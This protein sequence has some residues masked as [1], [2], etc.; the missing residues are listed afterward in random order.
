MPQLETNFYHPPSTFFG[1]GVFPPTDPS[2]FPLTSSWEDVWVGW[3]KCRSCGTVKSCYWKFNST[4]INV[5]L[6]LLDASK[7]GGY[8]FKNKSPKRFNNF[9]ARR[10]RVIECLLHTYTYR[11]TT[12]LI[13][14]GEGEWNRLKCNVSSALLSIWAIRNV[15]CKTGDEWERKNNSTGTYQNET[16]EHVCV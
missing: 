15:K 9:N 10:L 4:T 11:V 12:F 8:I 13:V 7:D 16:K 1:R 14:G 5:S 2:M 6:N 3:L